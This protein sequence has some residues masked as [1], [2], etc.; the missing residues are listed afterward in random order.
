MSGDR[1][2]REDPPGGRMSLDEYKLAMLSRV[3]AIYQ[4]VMPIV[5]GLCLTAYLFMLIVPRLRR[6]SAFVAINAVLLSMLFARLT[7]LGYM[8]VSS[9]RVINANYLSPLYPLLLAFC[10]LVA[11]DVM[12]AWRFGKI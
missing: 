4:A 6:R 2:V 12:Y 3:G 7:L 8:D 5:S 1:L 9:F 10:G 11:V